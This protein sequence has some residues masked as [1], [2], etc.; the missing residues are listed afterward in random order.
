MDRLAELCRKK[1]IWITGV[2]RIRLSTHIHTRPQ[3]IDLFFETV[4]EARRALGVG[5]SLLAIATPAWVK[6]FKA[7][8]KPRPACAR[9]SVQSTCY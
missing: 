2:E 6:E 3:D 8:A 1:R 4:A 7:A 5:L 9:G